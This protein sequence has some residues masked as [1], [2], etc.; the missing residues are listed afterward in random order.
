VDRSIAATLP[1]N[2]GAAATNW[3]PGGALAVATTVVA[4]A[5]VVAGAAGL[6]SC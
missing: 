2:R 5:T 1:R 6:A 4:T 3:V